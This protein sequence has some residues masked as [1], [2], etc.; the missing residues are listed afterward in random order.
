MVAQV[1]NVFLCRHP[2]K[3]S[4][5]FSPFSNAF[6][7]PGI[8]A[9]LGLILFIVYTP[10]GNWLFGTAPIGP[11]VWLLAGFF[12]ALMW[13]LEEARKVWLRRMSVQ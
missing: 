3:S 10:A 6:I 9:E 1:A 4:L 12:A 2:L 13:A 5:S 8:A 11:E 7:L